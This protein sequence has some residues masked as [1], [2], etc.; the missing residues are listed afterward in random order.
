V[1]ESKYDD[2][3]AKDLD[4]FVKL[5]RSV[6]E[7]TAEAPSEQNMRSLFAQLQECTG[8]IVSRIIALRESA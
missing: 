2:R 1:R 6:G 4:N 3:V 8:Q 5:L 7:G